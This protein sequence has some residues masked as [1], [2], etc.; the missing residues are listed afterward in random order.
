M[1]RYLLLSSLVTLCALLS[2]CAP[3]QLMT[4]PEADIPALNLCVDFGPDCPLA[5]RQEMESQL[6]SFLIDY[7][8]KGYP[9]PIRRCGRFPE[10]PSLYLTVED[11]QLISREQQVL[12]ALVSTVGL[13]VVP[14]LMVRSELP[15]YVWFAYLPRNVS[16]TA[17]TL[18]D[19]LA[20]YPSSTQI[21]E[22]SNSA[23]F[24][25]QGKQVERQ[26]EKFYEFLWQLVGELGLTRTH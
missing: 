5:I 25:S 15:F 8:A 19:D 7:Q 14:Y 21:R 24:R 23:M 1:K 12:G 9:T 26:G 17:V 3:L 18:S 20:R 16:H 10:A 4:K 6:D 11:G 22:V 2:G 13:V